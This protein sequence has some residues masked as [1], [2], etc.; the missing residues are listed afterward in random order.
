MCQVHFVS[1][2][3]LIKPGNWNLEASEKMAKWRTVFH[4]VVTCCAPYNL[5]LWYNS[6]DGW[7]CHELFRTS[8][9]P[10][11]HVRAQNNSWLVTL[12]HQRQTERGVLQVSPLWRQQLLHAFSGAISSSDGV[13]NVMDTVASSVCSRRMLP[14]AGLQTSC[15][16]SKPNQSFNEPPSKT[17][18][19][20]CGLQETVT[21]TNLCVHPSLRNEQHFWN[22]HGFFEMVLSVNMKAWLPC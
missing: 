1:P 16:E 7:V 12:R 21:T 22:C 3:S 15:L 19:H 4:I 8:L 2:Q 9:I 18:H 11:Q 5:R 17:N 20:L 6:I 10:Y 14:L 13:M